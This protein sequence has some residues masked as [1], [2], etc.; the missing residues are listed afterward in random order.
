MFE[1]ISPPSEWPDLS[2]P[3]DV[4][5]LNALAAEEEDVEG[6]GDDEG[7]GQVDEEI[8]VNDDTAAAAPVTASS[9][10]SSENTLV[11]MA[12][13]AVDEVAMEMSAVEQPSEEPELAEEDAEEDVSEGLL[14]PVEATLYHLGIPRPAIRHM[15]PPQYYSVPPGYMHQYQ[16][17]PAGWVPPPYPAPPYMQPAYHPSYQYYHPMMMMRPPVQP[18]VQPGLSP[19]NA[20]ETSASPVN[21]SKTSSDL[22]PQ[23]TAKHSP[24]P[25]SLD[26]H[27]LKQHPLPSSPQPP[28]LDQ[29]GLKQHPLPSSPQPPSLDQHGLKQHPLPSSEQQCSKRSPLPSSPTSSTSGIS[30]DIAHGNG[31]GN[32]PPPQGDRLEQVWPTTSNLHSESPVLEE[33]EVDAEEE[34]EAGSKDAFSSEVTTTE[35]E[36]DFPASENWSRPMK[37]PH[38]LTSRH[39][40]KKSYSM[41]RAT[42]QQHQPRPEQKQQQCQQQQQQQQHPHQQQHR[43]QQ[44]HPQQQ[45]QQ[46]RQ[47]QQSGGRSK[48][49]SLPIH[50]QGRRADTA[51]PKPHPLQFQEDKPFPR[52]ASPATQAQLVRSRQGSL[53]KVNGA[54]GHVD[55][56]MSMDDMSPT[57]QQKRHALDVALSQ[58]SFTRTEETIHSITYGANVTGGKYH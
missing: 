42:A 13:L 7:E 24:Q 8:I 38:E 53:R 11:T 58:Y 28:S 34:E 30:S 3:E 35:S 10:A 43:Q 46:N 4:G 12:T 19:D 1:S 57:A 54:P 40:G 21:G 2:P 15:V 32:P 55:Y 20:K 23:Q 33:M 49:Q 41:N 14:K 25:P 51:K 5:D 17:P 44:Q 36:S 39:K 29:H 47:Q 48:V 31:N 56:D 22:S 6:E 18:L 27:G 16:P 45:Q 26:Q 37:R 52:A 9:E 50:K